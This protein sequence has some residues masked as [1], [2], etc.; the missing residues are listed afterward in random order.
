MKRHTS[1]AVA[2]MKTAKSPPLNWYTQNNDMTL[3]NENYIV[4]RRAMHKES[5]KIWIQVSASHIRQRTVGRPKKRWEEEIN[6]C[7]KSKEIKE[8]KD[9]E[10]KNNDTWIKVAKIV[11]DEKQWNTLRSCNREAP[12]TRYKTIGPRP[13]IWHIMNSV[14]PTKNQWKCSCSWILYISDAIEVRDPQYWQSRVF[15]WAV[16]RGFDLSKDWWSETTRSRESVKLFSDPA[17]L[18]S[19]ESDDSTVLISQLFFLNSKDLS[20]LTSGDS[21]S[22]STLCTL[23][24][25]ATDIT[26]LSAHFIFGLFYRIC[27]FH[28]ENLNTII[29]SEWVEHF[30]DSSLM[31]IIFSLT[32]FGIDNTSL[33]GQCS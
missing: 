6:D 30:S 9:N 31:M 17:F 22:S 26:V 23:F 11:K 12:L 32:R 7:L 13:A 3:D 5:S 33:G 4:Y 18:S 21:I 25:S 10:L 8:T 28:S 15:E 1:I 14:G 20:L 2:R 16:V 24:F 29:W 19:T 27:N